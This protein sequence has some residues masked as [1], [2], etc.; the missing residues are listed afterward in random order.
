[1][2]DVVTCDSAILRS[3]L[4]G[5]GMSQNIKTY[6]FAI[7]AVIPTQLVDDHLHFVNNTIFKDT[8]RVR[9]Q[10]E[11]QYLL[12]VVVRVELVMGSPR[13]STAKEFESSRPLETFRKSD[14]SKSWEW[15]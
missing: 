7:K 13:N 14:T 6:I 9:L 4:P 12:L 11:N 15:K 1:M 10:V 5:K 8:W 2:S 3:N